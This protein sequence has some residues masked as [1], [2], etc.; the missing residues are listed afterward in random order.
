MENKTIYGLNF[1]FIILLYTWAFFVAVFYNLFTLFLFYT[2]TLLFL[3]LPLYIV[4]SKATIYVLSLTYF[5]PFIYGFLTFTDPTI[6]FN[7]L[8]LELVFSVF[9]LIPGFMI[10]YRGKGSKSKVVNGIGILFTLIEAF[11]NLEYEASNIPGFYYSTYV[12]FEVM[13][14][15]SPL[16]LVAVFSTIRVLPMVKRKDQAY[17]YPPTQQQ[18]VTQQYYPPNVQ[19][20][21]TQQYPAP[22]QYPPQVPTQ[23][24]YRPNPRAAVLIYR[25]LPP[26]CRPRISIKGN[27]YV[28]RVYYQGDYIFE[29]PT[30]IVLI[31]G[32]IKCQN[33]IYI[34][35]EM[36]VSVKVGRVTVI[37]FRPVIPLQQGTGQAPLQAP[38]VALM[39]RSLTDWD[40]NVW[41][42]RNLSVYKIEKVIGEGGNGYV[43]K[44]SY[45]G[46]YFAV[47]VLKLY[48]GSPEEYFKDLAT[49]A[50]NLVNLSNHKNIVKVYA[51][52]VDSFVIDEILKGKVETYVV[53][54]PMIVME[55]MEGGTLK[56]LL[57]NDM[58]YYSS[59]WQRVA[60]KATCEVAQALD[61]IHSQGFVHM[62][63]KPHNIF[64]T[65]KP[66]DSTELETLG[67]KL[68]D[69]GSAVRINGKIKQVTPEYSPPEVFE[70]TAKPYFDV[71]A[72]GMTAYVLLTRKVDRP[73]LQEMIDAIDCYVKNDMV[74][75]RDLINNSK[76]KLAT[77]TISI[78]PKV[79]QL[80]RHMLTAD[81]L[82]RPTAKDVVDMIRRIDPTIC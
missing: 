8:V 39:K 46:K 4:K 80:L 12:S 69:L 38:S 47:K 21:V 20:P 42:N 16:F 62:D 51:V 25:G 48:G 58:F 24:P 66:R 3:V 63:V 52:N 11:F 30:D 28:P 7:V 29:L 72:L 13:A 19:Q 23:P 1:L 40:P 31:V 9:G 26:N 78:D 6:V 41:V 37:N 55:F 18:P 27:L 79:D 54:P 82:K 53:N 73:D 75:V 81:P 14:A 74:C 65:V 61:Y 33:M 49:E 44:G 77:W 17:Y 76:N 10:L 56:D 15:L 32:N 68:G 71:F 64:L 43:L 67:F 36:R 59:K 57:E 2:F 70:T 50:S 60:L 5:Y 35:D 22:Q 34:P 45:S